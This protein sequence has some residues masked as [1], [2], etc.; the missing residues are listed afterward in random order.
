MYKDPPSAQ[1]IALEKQVH[2]KLKILLNFNQI[3]STTRLFCL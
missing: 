2:A 3:F 1:K